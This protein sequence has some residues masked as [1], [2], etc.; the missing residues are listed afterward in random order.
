MLPPDWKTRLLRLASLA[1]ARFPAIG[2]LFENLTARTGPL[3][4]SMIAIAMALIGVWL[5]SSLIYSV[6]ILAAVACA[7]FLIWNLVRDLEA[8]THERDVARN[9]QADLRVELDDARA[10]L[11]VTTD[12]FSAL[13]MQHDALVAQFS[14]APITPPPAVNTQSRLAGLFRPS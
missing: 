3:A 9:E 8:M 10:R 7:A 5:A 6:A 13:R 11:N 12:S 1:S 14:P 4:A 2:I